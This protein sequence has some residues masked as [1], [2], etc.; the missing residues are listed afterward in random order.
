MTNSKN[1][2]AQNCT[3]LNV[4]QLKAITVLSAIPCDYSSVAEVAKKVGVCRRTLYNWFEVDAF[5]KELKDAQDKNFK[6]YGSVVRSAHLK[7][8]LDNQNPRL[9]Q[10]YYERVEGWTPRQEIKD[11][12]SRPVFQFAVSR[13]PFMTG[14]VKREKEEI[15]KKIINQNDL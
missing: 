12:A 14:E 9:I 6:H 1:K 8:I 4:K 11:D 13:S 15:R 7:G 2:T 3:D 10:L 5:N